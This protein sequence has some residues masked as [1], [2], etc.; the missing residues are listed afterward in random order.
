MKK[1]FFGLFALA[2]ISAQA[3]TVEEI[4]QKYAIAVGGLENLRKVKTVKMSG[5]LKTQGMDLP[6]TIQ[7]INGR[8]IRSD[9]EVMGQS[10][11]SAYKDEKGWKI[12]PF[13]GAPSATDLSGTELTDLKNQS[14]LANELMDYKGHGNK[15]ELLGQE[16]V[17]GVKAY[18]IKL[19]HDDY[20]VTT[21]F[22]DAKSFMPVEVVSKNNI[23]GQETEVETYLTDAKDFEGLKFHTSIV[24]KIGG[25]QFS[26]VHLDK[27]DLNV[28]IDDKIFDKQ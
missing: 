23:M 21:Y 10:V 16:D 4:I 12:N 24:Q 2:V 5:T 26:E 8:A 17:N 22:I 6:I 25:Q 7:L 14:F 9:I 1:I 13:A 20:R 11:I 18:K 28:P 27:I 19:T 3:Q 15:V